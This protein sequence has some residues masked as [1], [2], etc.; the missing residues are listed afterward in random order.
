[1]L[2]VET[3]G[4]ALKLAK[5]GGGGGG[6]GGA[7]IDD[8]KISPS[9]TWSSQK[10]VD[11]LCP[12]FTA[13]GSVVQCY[14]VANYP[15]GVKV[16]WEPHQEGEGD[17]SP[18]N[19]RAISG[20]ESV[21][22][23]RCG[24]NLMPYTK[25]SESSYT[26]NGVTF[27]WNDDG[28]IHVSGTAVGRADSNVMYFKDFYLPPGKYRMINP[29]KPGILSQFVVKKADTG[30]NYWYNSQLII[31]IENGDVPQYF[32]ITVD[33]GTTVDTTIYAFLSYGIEKP[34]DDDYAPYTG[35]TATLTL[36]EIIYG[37]TVDVGTED[38]ERTVDVISLAVADMDNGESFPGW[39]NQSWI[40]NYVENT[41]QDTLFAMAADYLASNADGNKILRFNN[42]TVYFVSSTFGY[43][44]SQLKEQYPN[45]VFQFAFRRITPELF[46]P[47][48]TQQI[49]AISGTNTL[50][51]D[52]GNI[53]VTGVSDPGAAIATLQDRLTALENNT[54]N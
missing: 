16:A 47:T 45:L 8:S 36:P 3:L 2:D 17:P 20:M 32:Y 39:Q 27:T 29:G 40:T 5:K 54:L 26:S 33:D 23:T 34:T 14:P 48:S 52:A 24:K 25:P 10:I 21:T 28:S 30:A 18:D 11:T 50:Y 37:G 13:S 42:F 15:L 53:T 51:A 4:A 41:N 35:T 7:V 12:P 49:L 1:M 31:S 19:I 9:T 38:S 44:Q 22:V 46:H 43:T 6:E